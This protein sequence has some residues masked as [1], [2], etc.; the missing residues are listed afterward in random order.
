[1]EQPVDDEREAWVVA[2]E[3]RGLDLVI[4]VLHHGNRQ[5]DLVRNVDWYGRLGIAEYFVYDRLKQQLH[6]WRLPAGGTVYR[7]LRARRGRIHSDVLDLD[8]AV[9]N[10]TLRF[11]TGS[12]EL[13]GSAELIERLSGM[14]EAVEA[15]ADQAEARAREADARA[16]EADAVARRTL[17][18]L[19]GAVLAV[20]EAR[21]LAVPP[22]VAARVGACEDPELL[23]R[24]V[25]RAA[26]VGRA[27]EV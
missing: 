21:G 22:E 2:R 17:A 6:A 13:S 23:V 7:S 14:L 15:R 11:F 20:L 1:V 24:W 26:T 25:G 16:G 5:K 4:E 19:R 3:G 9:V 10:G 18:A 8:L 27:E 12:A